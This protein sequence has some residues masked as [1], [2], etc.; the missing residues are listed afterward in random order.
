MIDQNHLVRVMSDGLDVMGCGQESRNP[1]AGA[2]ALRMPRSTV[3]AW[4]R[5]MG[6]SR[7]PAPPPVPVQRY[8]WPRAGDLVHVD[9]KPLGRIGC[10][11]HRILWG[12]RR[13]ATPA[14]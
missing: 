8:E 1:H 3:S 7:P 10:V 4:L 2:C 14:R 5:R 6:L 11:G 12:D 9:I 13:R